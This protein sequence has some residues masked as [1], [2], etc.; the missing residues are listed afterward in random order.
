MGGGKSGG[1]LEIYEYT[2]SMHV[3]ICAAGQG[4]ELLNVKY[5]EKDI[6]NG[7]LK[8]KAA[9][10][11]NKINLLGGQKKEGGLRGMMTWLPGDRNQTLPGHIFSRLGLTRD[12]AP[13]F[14]GLASLFFSGTVDDANFD[15]TL[16]GEI[17]GYA[18]ARN[19]LHEAGDAGKVRG[20][21]WA[22]NNP[23]LRD[24]SARVRR[25]PIG[26]NP[27]I[28]LI[29]IPDASNGRKQYGANGA[30]IIYEC[31]TNRDWGMGERPE[32]FD[33]AAWETAAQ[34]LYDEKFAL[35]MIWT[36]QSDIESFI[37]EV[38]DHIQ[39]SLY[40]DPTT[41]KHTIKLLR[42]DYNVNSLRQINQSN[43]K[44]SNFRR[45]A[46]G[47]ITNEVTV[48]STNT[49]TGL[50]ESV[51]AQDL[52]AISMQGG[53][54]STTK[55]YYGA[56]YQALAVELAERDLAA[57]VRPLATCEASVSRAFWNTFT[58]EVLEVSWPEHNIERVIMRIGSVEKNGKDINLSLYE[59]IFGAERAKYLESGGTEWEDPAQQ[60]APLQ[61]IVFGT[62][63][64][65]MTARALGK[66]DAGD[67]EYPEAVAGLVIGPDSDDDVNFELTT[68]VRNVNGQSRRRSIG[69]RNFGGTFILPTALAAEATSFNV[70]Y[71]ALWGQAPA[72]GDVLQIS[73]GPDSTT[74]IVTVESI[75]ST[76]KLVLNRGTLDTTPKAWGVGTRVWVINGTADETE[77][78]AGEVVEYW[79]QTR[80][81]A[82]VL[83]LADTPM[84]SNQLSDR[85][86]RPNRPANVR[87]NGIGFGSVAVSLADQMIVTWANRNRTL[88]ATQIQKWGDAGVAREPG[89]TTVVDLMMGNTLIKRYDGLTGVSLS[90]PASEF[91]VTAN[92]RV[93]VRSQRDGFTSLQGHEIGIVV[94]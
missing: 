65:F 67:L 21:L 5:G 26:L 47:D 40:I 50:E 15:E 16:S 23:Y 92:A 54:T 46:W 58:G 77:R 86:Y 36:R 20:F 75:N 93:R 33:V 32:M 88:E 29:P 76:G 80:T 43:A 6:W 60:P 25:A 74:E 94:T 9:V 57:S 45:K 73:N 7:S 41:G 64:A 78:S 42:G 89:Q 3:G 19:T 48:T 28:A 12:T 51:T 71:G 70:N 37:G 53:I 27:S 66:S 69:T 1:K 68:W 17:D 39:A 49:E 35:N 79:P 34:T 24:I 2:M 10:A 85:A 18:A 59:D 61:H 55:N 4:I 87:V 8:R 82:G 44:L 56:A 30:H 11:V 83:D 81:S 72:V 91:G 14:R 63:P 38:Q 31:M 52:A 90:F 22:M 84:I 62:A 13:G